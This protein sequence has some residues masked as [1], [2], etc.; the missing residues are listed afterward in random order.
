MKVMIKS[1]YQIRIMNKKFRTKQKL[2]RN[3]KYLLNL[4]EIQFIINKYYS[5][6]D[7]KVKYANSYFYKE[8]N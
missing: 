5:K 3:K 4:V 1:F 7:L 2:M 6:K 8:T